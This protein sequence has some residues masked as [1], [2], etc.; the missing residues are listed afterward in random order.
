MA[1]LT[2]IIKDV[3]ILLDHNEQEQQGIE[4]DNVLLGGDSQL[5]LDSIIENQVA[6]AARMVIMQSP[7][8][9]IEWKVLSAGAGDAGDATKGVYVIP[10]PADFLRFGAAKLV[11]WSRAVE[12]YSS[13]DS[14]AY[15]M[16]QSEFGGVK[17]TKR[18]P[19]VIIGEKASGGNEIQLYPYGGAEDGLQFFTYAAQ[20]GVRTDTT[21]NTK[22]VDINDTLY[23]PFI[24]M[25]GA[26]TAEV[27][28][29]TDKSNELIAAAKAMLTNPDE[30]VT[31]NQ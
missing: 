15:A 2:N 5:Y 12:T 17:A 4:I 31:T 28:K 23:Q 30:V 9:Y 18:K 16:Q 6:A 25:L 11:K 3:R 29:D 14:D 8:D 22:V 19:V 27:L 10:M 7:R 20:I 13:M 1:Y 26:L 24:Y 21:N